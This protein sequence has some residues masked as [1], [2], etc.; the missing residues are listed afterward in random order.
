MSTVHDLEAFAPP[1]ED[2]PAKFPASL[3]VSAA[4]YFSAYAEETAR[5]S[6][7]L[8]APTIVPL[9]SF[10][11]VGDALYNQVTPA[12]IEFKSQTMFEAAVTFP[13]TGEYEIL[14][15]ASCDPAKGEN[16][17][18]RIHLDRKPGPEVALLGAA[19]AD[20]KAKLTVPFGERRLGIEF[21]N[22][23]WDEKTG[24]DRNLRVHGV[25][26]RRVR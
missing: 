12:G 9:G 1:A 16:A 25:A 5:A 2:T 7:A 6:R 18:F 26:F 3:Y 8:P 17:R 24:E 11:Q 22:D 19:P 4:T 13:E 21:T 15:A 20:Y 14:V 23:F 10:R